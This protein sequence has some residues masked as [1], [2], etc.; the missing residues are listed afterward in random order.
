MRVGLSRAYPPRN[1]AFHGCLAFSPNSPW[2]QDNCRG[3]DCRWAACQT[4]RGAKIYSW[5]F[6]LVACSYRKSLQLLRNMLSSF[7]ARPLAQKT[8]RLQ[9]VLK[10]QNNSRCQHRPRHQ[11]P[12]GLKRHLPHRQNWHPETGSNQTKLP[13][14][15]KLKAPRAAIGN[16]H[17]H[18]NQNGQGCSGGNK[19]AAHLSKPPVMWQEQCLY[20]R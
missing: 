19:V 17:Y 10:L 1:K 20:D 11:A 5:S 4:K 6:F 7:S 13:P 9:K 3:G 14:S 2:H 16:A 15:L 18:Q 8:S 12:I